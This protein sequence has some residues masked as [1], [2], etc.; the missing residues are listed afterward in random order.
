[1]VSPSHIVT[2]KTSTEKWLT[3]NGIAFE[4]RTLNTNAKDCQP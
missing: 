3:D 1:M 4:V 2:N